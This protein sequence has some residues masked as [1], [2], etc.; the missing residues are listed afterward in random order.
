MAEA[1][2][3]YRAMAANILLSD[4]STKDAVEAVEATRTLYREGR[5][6]IADLQE[7]RLMHL[8]VATANEQTRIRA[9]LARLR[10]LF[11]SGQL[12][13]REIHRLAT[14]FSN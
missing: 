11:L 8:N 4:Q 3:A 14:R 5:K 6:S 13:N 9:E 12:T 2:T 1:A 10:L 7:M